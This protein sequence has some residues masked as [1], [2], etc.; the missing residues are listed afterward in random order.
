MNK[1]IIIFLL[2]LIFN[3]SNTNNSYA[4]GGGV[5][6][7]IFKLFSKN[8][9][10]ATSAIKQGDEVLNGSKAKN[11]E[12]STNALAE[13]GSILNKIGN[14]TNSEKK[15]ERPKTSKF[16]KMRNDKSTAI[17]WLSKPYN[18]STHDAS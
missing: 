18:L 13:E 14:D 16:A 9:D 12:L 4:I 3:I 10:E 1:I 6:K 11:I 15:G 8:A 7:S 2:S 5:F 17:S